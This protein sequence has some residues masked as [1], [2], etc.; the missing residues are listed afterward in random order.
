MEEEFAQDLKK[1][2]NS[3]AKHINSNNIDLSQE[4]NIV[5]GLFKRYVKKYSMKG[6]PE[7]VQVLHK[8]KRHRD[9][10]IK[11]E[12]TQLHCQECSYESIGEDMWASNITCC[13]CGTVINP[14]FRGLIIQNNDRLKNLLRTCSKCG[15]SK[16]KMNFAALG[17]HEC[18]ICTECIRESFDAFRK[19]NKCTG[20]NKDFEGDCDNVIRSIVEADMTKEQLNQIYSQA[21]SGLQDHQPGCNYLCRA[22]REFER[23]RRRLAL[24]VCQRTYRR[25]GNR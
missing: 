3:L 8:S 16:D 20:C 1:L 18:I 22:Q 7:L 2:V 24:F 17:I 9:F 4:V 6:L 12:C 21:L 15:E 19:K 10:K 13:P 11:L 25:Q 23:Y 5:N 14:K